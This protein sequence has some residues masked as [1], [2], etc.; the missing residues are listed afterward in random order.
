M[1]KFIIYGQIFQGFSVPRANKVGVVFAFRTEM[2]RLISPFGLPP[3]LL[4]PL[5]R[6]LAGTGLKPPKRLVHWKAGQ[7]PAA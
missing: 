1:G 7:Y 4:K 3:V 6:L 5:A 2:I